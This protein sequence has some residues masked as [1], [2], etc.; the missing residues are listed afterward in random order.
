MAL[1]AGVGAVW[2]KAALVGGEGAVWVEAALV[3][4]GVSGGGGRD[5]R[6]SSS[7]ML[8]ACRR[9]R[10][11]WSL[12]FSSRVL[13]TPAECESFAN[14]S[15]A[16]RWATSKLSCMLRSSPPVSRL[17]RNRSH[18]AHLKWCGEESLHISRLIPIKAAVMWSAW[19]G[20]RKSVGLDGSGSG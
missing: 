1:V 13:I 3:G 9:M 14:S 17:I 16:N 7:R 19:L 8:S 2:V 5:G 11:A 4:G 20:S 6:L 10:S 18:A 12:D 15:S